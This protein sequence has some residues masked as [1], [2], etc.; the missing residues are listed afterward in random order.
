VICRRIASGVGLGLALLV[1]AAA[2]PLVDASAPAV[3]LRL[4]A[5]TIG[6]VLVD[7]AGKTVY[8]FEADRKGRSRCYGSC[9]GTWPPVLARGRPTAAGGA[10]P[11]LTGTIQRRNGGL[12]AT[13]AGHPLTT[14]P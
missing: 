3:K 4:R 11:A 7:G 9:A 5:T 10:R 8:L 14:T 13:Y 1:V 6:R 12:Q 2:P